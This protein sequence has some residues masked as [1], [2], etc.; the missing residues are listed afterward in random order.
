MIKAILAILLTVTPAFARVDPGT[1]DLMAAAEQYATVSVDTPGDCQDGWYG[2]YTLST[3]HLV[4]CTKGGWDGEDHDTVRHEVWHLI[5]H[6]TYGFGDI[7][8]PVLDKDELDEWVSKVM[9]PERLQAF[10]M[11]YHPMVLDSELEA[12]AAAYTFSAAQVEQ[13]LHRACG[14]P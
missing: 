14:N 11:A 6:C 13:I 7:L 9:T 12:S 5:Q 10:A 1:G 3:R 2:S 4:I 8:K